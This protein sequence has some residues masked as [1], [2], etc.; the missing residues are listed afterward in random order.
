MDLFAKLL[1]VRRM[2]SLLD[3]LS[4]LAQVFPSVKDFFR[5]NRAP[6]VP[7]THRHAAA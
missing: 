7:G 6:P 5:K 4:I 2:F 1:E 3:Y